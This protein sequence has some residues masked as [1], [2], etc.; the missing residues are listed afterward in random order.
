M[1]DPILKF[2]PE[3]KGS[4][5]DAEDKNCRGAAPPVDG[6][7]AALSPRRCCSWCCRWWR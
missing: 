2:P 3:Q 5:P 6:G 4:P 7:H 1:A